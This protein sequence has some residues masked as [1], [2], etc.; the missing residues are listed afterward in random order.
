MSRAG[1]PDSPR[2][3]FLAHRRLLQGV[4]LAPGGVARRKLRQAAELAPEQG[5][6]L[7][8]RRNL[9][10]I[11]LAPAS[12]LASPDRILAQVGP[13]L[14]RMPDD[15][16]A[17]AAYGVASQYVRLGQWEAAREL[18]LLMI[19]RYPAQ[20]LSVDACRWLIRHAASSE[21]RRR[22]ELKQF[23]MTTQTTVQAGEGV[24]ASSTMKLQELP[25]VVGS[26]QLATLSSP[27]E[28]RR[29]YENGLRIGER[30]AGLGPLYANDPA[31]QFSLQACRRNLG[32]FERA[33]QW[34][35]QFH[36]EHA[37]GPWREA[38]AAEIWLGNR[39]GQP[40][41]PVAWCRRAAVAPFLDGQFKDACWQGRPPLV[42][43]SAAGDTLK[44][45]PTEAWL[46][47]DQDFLYVGVKCRHPEN[48]FVAPVKVRPRDADLRSHDRVS[49]LIDLDRDYSSYFRLEVDQ[50]GCL[51]DDC[52][53]DRSWDPRWFVA[54][55]NEPNSWQI[56]VAIP[57]SE[58]TGET[59]TAGKAW[60]FNIVR[61][62]PGRG[63]QAWSLP[64]DVQPRPEGMGLLLFID[65]G[66]PGTPPRQGVT[67]LTP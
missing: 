60:A 26:R 6:A 17:Q 57:L 35:A 13:T 19:D 40:P 47:Y 33:R 5:K 11:L 56:E 20:P 39:V 48:R 21:A 31:I 46:A 58:L 8:A 1:C 37:D 49:L 59:V 38:A 45:Y 44:D 62:L 24:Q 30:L 52:W 34:Y 7:Q 23:L 63:V 36:A 9:D 29:W 43:K 54:L 14:S 53:G 10:S 2:P 27:E 55:H 50:R 51:C 42:L 15:Q 18:F 3:P 12:S 32:D 41:K 64:A 4:E 67:R 22:H 66:R 25:Q 16:G 65:D 28:T 61:I